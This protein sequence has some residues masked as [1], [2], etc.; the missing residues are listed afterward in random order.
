MNMSNAIIRPISRSRSRPASLSA[1][2]GPSIV[3]Q[4]LSASVRSMYPANATPLSERPRTRFITRT[5][6]TAAS[7]V[8]IGGFARCF[9]GLAASS[10]VS[11]PVIRLPSA[12][13]RRTTRMSGWWTSKY[14]ANTKPQ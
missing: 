12:E 8:A 7:V 6:G 10:R 3:S 5:D 4:N 11:A 14:S 1:P 13:S 2:G 9:R